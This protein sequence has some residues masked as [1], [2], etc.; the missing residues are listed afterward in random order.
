MFLNTHPHQHDTEQNPLIE[1]GRCPPKNLEKKLLELYRQISFKNLSE[2][3]SIEL[4]KAAKT[5]CKTSICSRDI[6]DLFS[7]HL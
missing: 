3:A 1:V 2:K 5:T 4:S 6:L 7:L